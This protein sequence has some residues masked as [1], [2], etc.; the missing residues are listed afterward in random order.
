M[1]YYTK[2]TDLNYTVKYLEQ[3]TD[4]VLSAEKNVE[5]KKFK[6]SVTEKAIDIEGYT[7]VNPEESITIE[8]TGNEII[9]YYTKR[10]DL[11]YTVKYLE[12]DTNKELATEKVVDRQ[13]YKS[14]ATEE[15][16]D[17]TGY[18]KV[19]SEERI[20]IE[21]SGNEI[22]F[23]YKKVEGLSY[24]VNYYEDG[25][26][27][28]VATSKT[29]D[30][31]IFEDEVTETAIN[32]EGY[33]KVNPTENTIVIGV[34]ENVINFYYTKRVDLSYTVKYLEEG[35][36]VELSLSKTVDGKTFEE[37][38]TET[39]R[40]IE[41]YDKVGDTETTI[42]MAVSGNEI[43][44]YYAKRTDLS[45]TVKYLEQD[46]NEELL[47]EKV[48]NGKTFQETITEQSVDIAG[49][50]KVNLEESIVIEVTGN[51]ITFYYTKKSDIEYKVE[52]YYEGV[53][54]SSKTETHQATFKQIIDSY[55][56]NDRVGYKLDEEKNFPLQISANSEENVIQIYYVID[57]E[58][59]KEIKYTVEYYKEG[60]LIDIDTQI[61]TKTVQVLDQEVLTVNKDDIN[62]VDKY[63][64]YRLDSTEPTVIP[65]EVNNGDVIKVYYV[66]D[67]ANTKTL[68]YTVEYYK[69][70]VLVEDDTETV[71]ETVQILQ[72]DTLDVRKGEINT[73]NKYV[74]YKL[75]E[76]TP[77]EIPDKIATGETIKVYY[78]IDENQRKD[79]SYTIEY[80]KDGELQKDE[81]KEVSI[82]VQ[83]LQPDTIP[84]DKAEMVLSGKYVG[85]KLEKTSP[86]EIPAI[87]NNGDVIRIYYIKDQFN[88]TVEYYYD[89]N[90]D[91][92]KTDTF[93]AT[94][95]DVIKEYTDKNI[96][97]Y[98]LEKTEGLP[99]EISEKSEENVIKVYYIIDDGNTKTLNYT[100]EYYMDGVLQEG[101]TQLEYKTVQVLQPDTFEVDKSKINLV[102]KYVGYKLEKTE[103]DG[104]PDVA[105]TGD[106]YKVYYVKE[107]FGYTVEYYYEGQLNSER[108]ENLTAL[109]DTIID[110]YPNKDE[111]KY[112]IDYTENFPMKISENTNNNIIKIHYEKKLST[113]TVHYYWDGVNNTNNKG[114]NDKRTVGQET[115]ENGKVSV[116]QDVIIKD[117]VDTVHTISAASDVT[118]KYELVSKPISEEITMT[119]E[120]Q[121]FEYIYRLKD[122]KVT[123]NFIEVGTGKI[124]GTKV[125][126]GQVDDRYHAV[127][128]SIH[129][130]G[131]RYDKIPKNEVGK[132]TLEPIT[133]NFYYDAAPQGT[134]TTQ[135]A[136]PAEKTEFKGNG[137]A[138][139]DTEI[140]V[141]MA[142]VVAILA[143]NISQGKILK[144]N[145]K[146]KINGGK[147]FRKEKLVGKRHSS[148]VPSK[149]ARVSRLERD[150]K[151]GATRRQ[152]K[153]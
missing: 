131:L 117:K 73:V 105:T 91:N 40:D 146:E 19:N 5:N 52:F 102:D 49:Y 119:V 63:F 109:Y 99:L 88:Y 82:N 139:G 101:D 106:V 144:V 93:T 32:V 23:Y 143:I 8:V 153:Y 29:V 61:N 41:G 90:I 134:G 118:E 120:P 108:T 97:G 62:I 26:Q 111:G 79:L 138:T 12:Q 9:F 127:P 35:S 50:N 3:D 27:T 18:T 51:E 31:K 72:P 21:V 46:S 122:A 92:T 53:L 125:M 123:V 57:D 113:I 76:T 89:G 10:T 71:S 6:E 11:S 38:V 151:K 66:I 67:E 96:F 20:T 68:N 28:K 16:I 60:T 77:S 137:P 17:I 100:V 124:L 103:P 4:K 149:V 130:F 147:K 104:I 107:T 15:A 87:A 74:G 98:R 48:V 128:D 121:E 75:Q 54:D 132:M 129:G 84:V 37:K 114:N 39:A 112:Y 148:K 13:T 30:G 47:T 83:L 78:V 1:F 152:R 145:T 95:E 133:V 58:Q 80:Y 150:Y 22:I 25:T 126:E 65:D 2:R 42:T 70:G 14:E 64:G 7:K 24:T 141:C 81:T 86:A 85:Y 36:N 140:I 56:D 110:K 33:D 45:Y 59:T 135:T 94:Y 43:I 136:T 142:I 116:S 34:G 115:K 44:F 55:T 69:E